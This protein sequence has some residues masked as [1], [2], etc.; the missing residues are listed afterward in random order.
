M[1]LPAFVLIENTLILPAFGSFTGFE[2]VSKEKFN[3]A[4]VVQGEHVWN[5]K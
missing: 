1:R 3:K 5:T 2:D 4:W